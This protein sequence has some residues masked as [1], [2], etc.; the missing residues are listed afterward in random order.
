MKRIITLFALPMF[1]AVGNVFSQDYSD[2]I[3]EEAKSDYERTN[4]VYSIS[5]IAEKLGVSSTELGNAL[6]AWKPT[7]EYGNP[8]SG[9]FCL[10][11]SDGTENTT[12]TAS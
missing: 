4:I 5:E 12:P 9:L 8:R 2:E 11:Q 7:E 10:V 1:F 6:E 3:V